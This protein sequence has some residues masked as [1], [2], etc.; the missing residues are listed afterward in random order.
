MGLFAPLKY[1]DMLALADSLADSPK[2]TMSKFYLR[3]GSCKAYIVGTPNKYECAIIQWDAEPAEP[4]GFGN[5]PEIVFDLL[6]SVKGW[7][8]IHLLNH[9]CT[10]GFL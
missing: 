10:R 3:Q 1:S 4:E 5:D 8:C 6:Q 2:H 7:N 9:N